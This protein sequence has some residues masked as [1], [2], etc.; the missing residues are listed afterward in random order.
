VWSVNFVWKRI[1]YLRLLHK[2]VKKGVY[3]S[4]LELVPQKILSSITK[5]PHE[6][7]ILAGIN[8]LQK[9]LHIVQIAAFTN[10]MLILEVL[11]NTLKY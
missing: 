9:V 3:Q 6:K 2:D 1:E 7:Q 11:S 8:H 5:I 4:H 10:I